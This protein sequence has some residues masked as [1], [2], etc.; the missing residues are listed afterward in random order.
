MEGKKEGW[1]KEGAETRREGR[2]R[3]RAG[4]QGVGRVICLSVREGKKDK[5]FISDSRT[6]LADSAHWL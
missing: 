2:C 1:K 4:G 3:L 6:A 5:R